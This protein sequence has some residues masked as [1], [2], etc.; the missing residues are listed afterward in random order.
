MKCAEPQH[1]RIPPRA[2]GGIRT[3]KLCGFAPYHAADEDA[4]HPR[5][6]ALAQAHQRWQAQRK[7]KAPG[8]RG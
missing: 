2:P 1:A 8:A 7:A 4:Q 3:V 5:Y 6:L